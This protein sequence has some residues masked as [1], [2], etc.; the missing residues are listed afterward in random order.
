MANEEG[1]E[2]GGGGESEGDDIVT[3]VDA[4]GNEIEHYWLG[5]V[6]L[7]EER[8]ALLSPVDEVNEAPETTNVYVY[9]YSESEDGAEE[10]EAVEDEA[11][12]AR[13]QTAAEK[14]FAEADQA[15]GGEGDGR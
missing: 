8:F 5:C 11:L 2:G 9:R 13:V 4:D 12:L 15:A 7:D 3:L 14:M 6:E 1:Q 10:F